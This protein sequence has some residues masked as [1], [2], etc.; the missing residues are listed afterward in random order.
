AEVHGYVATQ[1]VGRS[2]QGEQ[3]GTYTAGNY[4][5]RRAT[6][7]QLRICEYKLT[8]STYD[9][10]YQSSPRNHIELG[11]N[12][13]EQSYREKRERMRPVSHKETTDRSANCAPDYDRP[14]PA[15]GTLHERPE[16]GPDYQERGD[17][18]A[19]RQGHP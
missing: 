10:R 4:P 11:E 17:R 13:C 1:Q 18:Q 2:Q 14:P 19:E 7:G 5:G 6:N 9:P 16:Q 8:G 15:A 12:E 3:A